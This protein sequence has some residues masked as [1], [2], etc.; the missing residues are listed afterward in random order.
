M[1]KN[2]L[3]RP[4][5]S[6]LIIMLSIQLISAI[7]FFNKPCVSFIV[8]DSKKTTNLPDN[9]RDIPFLNISG[10]AQFTPQ[11]IINLKKAINKENLVIADLRQESHGFTNDLSISFYSPYVTLNDGMNTSE[12]IKKEEKELSQIKI[13][14]NLDI[15]SKFC[16]VIENIL[17]KTVSSE[18]NA[19]TQNKINYKR[20]AVKDGGIPTP[21]I[22][23]DFVDFIK[24]K[25][26]D[27]HVHFHCDA[28]DG[29]TTQFMIMYQTMF[30]EKNASLQEIQNFQTNLGT[31]KFKYDKNRQEFLQSFYDYVNNN[32]SS[33]Y[34]KP[35]SKWIQ[36]N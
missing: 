14:K 17:V 20:F 8:L 3:L 6:I 16:K 2:K 7:P 27:Q 18:G 4:I 11:Q 13:G 33:N 9:Y 28:G 26:Q 10:S 31:V 30:N 5:L 12:V 23:D 21:A 34:S 29:R 35:Y 24:N 32:K 36:E 1:K 19:V 22:V 25:P 15:Y